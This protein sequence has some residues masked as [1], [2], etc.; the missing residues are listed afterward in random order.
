[1]I[2]GHTISYE[3][4]EE[5]LATIPSSQVTGQL[6]FRFLEDK[7]TVGGEVQYNGAPAGNPIA[8]DYTL[9]NAFASYQATENFRLDFRADNIF[10][11]NYVNPLNGTTVEPLYEPGV[12]L[13]LAATVRFGG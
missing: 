12:S 1:M 9:V 7:L 3:G 5:D 11:V 2:E 13:K 10:D 4:V 6:G 8:E